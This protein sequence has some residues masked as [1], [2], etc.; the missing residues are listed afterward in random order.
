MFIASFFDW[1]HFSLDNLGEGASA[2][3]DA[4]G[5][6]GSIWSTLA[7]VVSIILA[8]IIIATRLG[9]VQMPA[10]P[11]NWTWGQVWGGGGATVVVLMLLKAW[12]ILAYPYG[13]FGIGFWI[14]AF[15]A[16]AIAYGGYLLYN[17]EKTGASSS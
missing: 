12:R 3:Y 15:A 1:W 4:W 6:P 10:L 14:G 8:G 9:K 7:V 17:A 2:G 5:D 11:P 16:V 13:G